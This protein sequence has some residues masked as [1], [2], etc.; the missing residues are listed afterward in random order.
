MSIRH[1]CT[2]ETIVKSP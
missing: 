1:I 2:N